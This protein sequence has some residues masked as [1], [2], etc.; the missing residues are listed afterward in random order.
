MTS[1]EGEH[2]E[3]KEKPIEYLTEYDGDNTLTGCMEYKRKTTP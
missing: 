3:K 2:F 1:M